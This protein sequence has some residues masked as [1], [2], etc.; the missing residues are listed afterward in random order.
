MKRGAEVVVPSRNAQLVKLQWVDAFNLRDMNTVRRF[1]TSNSV[2]YFYG[3]K[4]GMPLPAFL[5]SV[6]ELYESFPDICLSFDEIKEVEEN[7]VKITNFRS[8]G[9]HT[10]K[11]FAFGPFP[12]VPTSGLE[13]VEDPCQLTIRLSRGKMSEF[14]IDMQPGDLVGPPGYYIKIGGKMT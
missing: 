3:A 5:Q 12:P 1:C 4:N 11:P 6:E 8:Q 7:V 10:G 14:I 13:V 9:T 2:C